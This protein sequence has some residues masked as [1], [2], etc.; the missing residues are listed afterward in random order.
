MSP[1]KLHS[2]IPAEAGIHMVQLLEFMDSRLRGNDGMW[3]VRYSFT[4][5]DGSLIGSSLS[6]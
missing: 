1:K 3:K 5:L 2:V 6:A 4:T